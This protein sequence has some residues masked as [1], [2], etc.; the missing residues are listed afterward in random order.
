VEERIAAPV[1][2]GAFSAA[3]RE[4]LA[5]E[6]GRYAWVLVAD[7]NA[8]VE[9]ASGADAGW[10]RGWFPVEP[11]AEKLERLISKAAFV[12]AAAG[13]GIAVPESRVCLTLEAAE[14]AAAA[15]GYPVMVKAARS[16][17]GNGVRLAVSREELAG[18]FRGLEKRAPLV[19]Q[20]FEVG[21][22]GS[23][24]VLFDR[25]RPSCWAS[26]YKVEVFPEPFGPSTARE[27]MVHG[28]M[29][30][31]L[32]AVGSLTGFHGIAGVDWM[33]RGSDGALL[34]LEFNPRP[35]PV[36]HLGHLSGV[37]FSAAIGDML[38]GKRSVQRPRDV[39]SRR[40]LLFPQEAV[41]CIEYRKWRELLA[42]LPGGS[43]KDIAWDQPRLLGSQVAGLCGRMWGA[44]RQ[45]AGK[46]MG[47]G[48]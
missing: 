19:V 3:L 15:I 46:V 22:V 35:P 11:E 30:G 43:H 5:R 34:V 32:E 40:V 17:G 2:E 33:H 18:A 25:G 20:R 31:M 6:G 27:L 37:D 36:V 38:A 13:A 1:E 10:L 16:F 41:R 26:S 39:G 12:A 7:E 9:L 28:E 42:F 48:K 21:R 24:Q 14:G 8:L 23:T 45:K 47:G 44:A 29:E 4:H